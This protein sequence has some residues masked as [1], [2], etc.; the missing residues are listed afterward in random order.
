MVSEGTPLPDLTTEN[1]AVDKKEPSADELLSI[2]E[3]QVNVEN[4]DVEEM[5]KRA[6]VYEEKVAKATAKQAKEPPNVPALT[7]E[8]KT[9]TR[10]KH[11]QEPQEGKGNK[12]EPAE[13]AK[14]PPALRGKPSR[15]RGGGP[16]AA[17]AR[18]T[19]NMMA[20]TQRE[21]P[22]QPIPSAEP[23]EEK[24]KQEQVSVVPE[25][26]DTPVLGDEGFPEVRVPSPSQEYETL[27][28]VSMQ[29]DNVQTELGSISSQIKVLM[30]EMA[31]QNLRLAAVQDELTAI[32]KDKSSFMSDILD[33]IRAIERNQGNL[34]A[35]TTTASSLVVSDVGQS[36]S[37]ASK[38][39]GAPP[40]ALTPEEFAAR[41]KQYKTQRASRN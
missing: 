24:G 41:M 15:G 27:S 19:L 20:K 8:E 13:R 21:P 9:P 16:M 1:S 31:E 22:I 25:T 29:Q 2:A 28:F 14:K 39:Y 7:A 36:M 17:A 10:L 5:A 18:R 23:S 11:I 34:P 35:T 38:P 37:T 30:K 32:K 3:E 26:P 40:S 12:G 6:L 4:I 33:R